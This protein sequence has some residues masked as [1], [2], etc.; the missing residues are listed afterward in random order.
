ME[1]Y[2]GNLSEDHLIKKKWVDE[3]IQIMKIQKMAKDKLCKIKPGENKIFNQNIEALI[4]KLSLKLIK[5][6]DDLLDI[7]IDANLYSI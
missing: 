2:Q 7:A 4:N 6:I 1:D 3:A 5:N